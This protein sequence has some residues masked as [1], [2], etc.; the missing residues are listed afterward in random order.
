MFE[1]DFEQLFQTMKEGVQTARKKGTNSK[2]VMTVLSPR[3]RLL[4][5]LHWLRTNMHAK[6]LGNIYKIHKSTVTREIKHI[7][8]KLYLAL[9]PLKL[10][11]FP[12]KWAPSAFESVVGAIDCGSHYRNRVHPRQADYYRG[13][14]HAH[15]LTAQ[16][17][18]ALDGTI[19][20][21]VLGLGHNNDSGMFVLSGTKEF[22]SNH[23]IKLV[24]DRGYS[25]VCLVTPD[26]LF[27]DKKWNNVQKSLRSV[28]EVV[29]GLAKN[30]GTAAQRFRM[31][32]E[33]HELVLIIVYTLV[34]LNLLSYPLRTP[35]QINSTIN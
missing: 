22:L 5:V 30:W 31:N 24:A 15:F 23:G 6:E 19:L 8:P 1:D 32:P 17:I 11:R 16:V 12:E 14:K 28:V 35:S 21:V 3:A 27:H 25:H 29:I 13:D 34:Q 10:I 18:T 33:I 2:L 9:Q 4:M 20:S 26:D 7:I